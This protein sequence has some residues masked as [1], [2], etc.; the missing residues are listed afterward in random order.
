MLRLGTLPLLDQPG[1]RWMYDTG[2]DVLGVLI[3]RA[4]GQPLERFFRTRIFEPLG[5]KNT[6]F[7]RAGGEDRPGRDQLPGQ[8]RNGAIDL[9]DVAGRRPMEPPAPFPSGAGGLVST[10]G[11]F[12]AF[13]QMMLNRGKLGNERILS[14]PLIELITTGHPTPEQKV[15]SGLIPGYFDSHGWGSGVTIVIGR[16]DVAGSIGRF[17][18]DGGPVSRSIIVQ[19]SQRSDT[20]RSCG[21]IFL[22]LQS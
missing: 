5:R 12:L 21:S 9:Y 19:F 2:S 18:W 22:I 13:G 20:F 17:G 7:F 14:R 10:A 3:A 11:D 4:S 6:G 16:D 15:V 1:E 8:S